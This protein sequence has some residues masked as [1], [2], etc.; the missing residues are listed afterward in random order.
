MHLILKNIT[1]KL[2]SRNISLT[3]SITFTGFTQTTDIFEAG[4][5]EVMEY[6][7]T[8][9]EYGPIALT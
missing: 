3:S 4:R 6:I 7:K 2:S 9:S 1:P 5:P 8:G